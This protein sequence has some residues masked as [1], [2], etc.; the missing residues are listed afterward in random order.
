MATAVTFAIQ[1]YDPFV[2][3]YFLRF[4]YIQNKNFFI[5]GYQPSASVIVNGL[6]NW[7]DNSKLTVSVDCLAKFDHIRN[8]MA[9]RCSQ[10]TFR[11]RGRCVY[12]P[13]KPTLHRIL[14][15]ER[16]VRSSFP[17]RVRMPPRSSEELVSTF[18]GSTEGIYMTEYVLQHLAYASGKN[19]VDLK[20]QNFLKNGDKLLEGATIKDCNIG[21]IT[22]QLMS[23]A[24][25]SDR[26]A[27]VDQF[28][29]DNRWRKRGI[30]VVPMRFAV[31]WRNGN[32]NCLVAIFHEGGTIAVTHGGIELG[33]GI[34]T[35]VAINRCLG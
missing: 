30:S 8:R 10:S 18:T 16:Q 32:Y 11:R 24:A 13:A 33:Q 20:R 22:E 2:C 12:M 1:G 15:V 29:K 19:P 26:A 9:C 31:H 17:P 5:A 3:L 4:Y 14:I 28:N 25:Y 35:K 27:A 6:P 34:N 21:P 7:V 23:N